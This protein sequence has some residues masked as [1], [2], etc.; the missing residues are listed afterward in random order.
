MK[1]EE[2]I[3][4]LFGSRFQIKAIKVWKKIVIYLILKN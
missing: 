2:D 3:K 1:Y 4:S